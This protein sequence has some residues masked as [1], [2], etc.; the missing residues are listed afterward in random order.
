MITRSQEGLALVMV[1]ESV[2]TLKGFLALTELE[3]LALRMVLAFVWHRGRM[4]CSAAAGSLASATVH[5]GEL[6][7][8]L[9]RPLWQKIDFNAPLRKALLAKEAG[10]GRVVRLTFCFFA[11]REDF[12][13][14]QTQGRRAAIHQ[15]LTVLPKSPP[16]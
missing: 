8:F 4:S 7:R 12:E 11:R 2:R 3:P 10:R 15:T 6:T 5:R 9:A 13:Q 14:K 1:A 16:D